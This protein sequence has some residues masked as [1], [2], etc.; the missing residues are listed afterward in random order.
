MANKSVHNICNL[1]FLSQENSVPVGVELVFGFH[2]GK[3]LVITP[4]NLLLAKP[5]VCISKSTFTLK[6]FMF[7]YKKVQETS[8]VQLS[9]Y[10]NL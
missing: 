3:N 2:S 7:L 4:C 6:Q 10:F 9:F 8:N 1:S 5:T